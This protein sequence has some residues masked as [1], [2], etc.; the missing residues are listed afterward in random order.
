MNSIGENTLF[1]TMFFVQLSCA[2]II[3]FILEKYFKDLLRFKKY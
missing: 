3:I 1:E 2:K